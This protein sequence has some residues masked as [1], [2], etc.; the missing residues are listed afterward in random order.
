MQLKVAWSIMS[1]LNETPNNRSTTP[2]RD[3]K[4][5]IRSEYKLRRAELDTAVRADRD[6]RICEFALGLVSFRFAEYVLLYA[7]TDDEI[8]INGIAEVALERG[9][10]LAFPRCRKEDHTM[11]YHVVDSLDQLQPDSYGIREPSE[12]LPIYDP[13]NDMGSAICFVPGLVYDRSGYRLG[14]GKG[15][16]DRFLS[17]FKGSSVGIVYS[18]FIL[19][20]V[21]RGRYDTKVDILLSEKGVKISEG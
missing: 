11:K 7:A 1:S 4:N 10:K 19:P 14:Y 12:D 20:E 13:E 3:R 17:S 5:I 16:Y 15:F 2:V 9:K 8:N 6:K 21:P 18:D